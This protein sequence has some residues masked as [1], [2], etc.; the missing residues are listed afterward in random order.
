MIWV[1][2]ESPFPSIAYNMVIVHGFLHLA[3]PTAAP[4][5]GAATA[6]SS[7]DVISPIT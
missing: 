2:T 5:A 6:T 4:L 3:A 7:V 1:A